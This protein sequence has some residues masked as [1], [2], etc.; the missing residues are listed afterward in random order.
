MRKGRKR[1]KTGWQRAEKEDGKGR[2]GMKE[3]KGGK[4]KEKEKAENPE[5]PLK[6]AIFIKLS[7]LGASVPTHPPFKFNT[8]AY[9][10][11]FQFPMIPRSFTY[12]N[13]LMANWR[14]QTLSF[15]KRDRQKKQKANKQKE[16][17]NFFVPGRRAIAEPHQTWHGDRGGPY[18]SCISDTFLPTTNS[19]AAWSDENLG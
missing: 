5:K 3:G 9:L 1:G 13:V 12:S 4:E 18:L 10:Q 8:D 17:S 6:T 7:T 2:M 14:S 19:F 16:T 11:T 15:N